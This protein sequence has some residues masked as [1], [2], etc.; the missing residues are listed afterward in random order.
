MMARVNQAV[1][2]LSWLCEEFKVLVGD[3]EGESS[4]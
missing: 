1:R 2:R 3:E 4:P